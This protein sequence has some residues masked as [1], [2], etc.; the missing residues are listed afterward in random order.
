MRMRRV[1]EFLGSPERVL[2][3]ARRSLKE[4][5]HVFPQGGWRSDGRG[6]D[7]RGPLWITVAKLGEAE[8]LEGEP[9]QLTERARDKRR[10]LDDAYDLLP[11]LVVTAPATRH[12][13]LDLSTSVVLDDDA[14]WLEFEADADVKTARQGDEIFVLWP[15]LDPKTEHGR[16]ALPR[17]WRFRKIALESCR[18]L[19]MVLSGGS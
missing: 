10:Q 4:G 6:D 14:A 18:V 9:E 3:Q 7:G 11:G 15:G 16:I 8:M 19:A 1:V 5:E 2:D 12:L 13:K 17:G